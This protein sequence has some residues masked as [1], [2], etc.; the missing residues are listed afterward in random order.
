MQGEGDK[1]S[2]DQHKDKETN[3]IAVKP[4]R[5]GFKGGHSK[6]FRVVINGRRLTIKKFGI[7]FVFAL[8]LLTIDWKQIVAGV[9][10]F[11]DRA[12]SRI[13]PTVVCCRLAAS[14]SLAA[15]IPKIRMPMSKGMDRR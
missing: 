7:R 8:I 15:R 3:S 5:K 4:R 6:I 13:I 1:V 2:E 14:F 10:D 12:Q 9:A 11:P